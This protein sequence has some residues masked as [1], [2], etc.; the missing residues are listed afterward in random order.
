MGANRRARHTL[1]THRVDQRFSYVDTIYLEL[2]VGL[3]RLAI[4]VLRMDLV[5][6]L[7]PQ[8]SRYVQRRVTR[9]SADGRAFWYWTMLIHQPTLASIDVLLRTLIPF[10]ITQVHV[11]LDLLVPAG[12]DP[13]ALHR[14][15]ESRLIVSKTPRS[16]LE[17]AGESTTYFNKGTRRGSEVALYS[18]RCSKADRTCACLHIEWRLMGA[19]ALVR[20]GLRQLGDIV[21]LNHRKFWKERLVLWRP[22]SRDQVHAARRRLMKRNELDGSQDLQSTDVLVSHVFRFADGPDHDLIA[23]NLLCFLAEHRLL[24]G[25]RPTR[26]FK[27]EESDWM[28]PGELNAMWR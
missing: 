28:L 16:R 21:H 10:R 12:S 22:P 3:D 6:A 27:R 24:F 11:A 2:P 15:I 25:A 23:N 1:L 9:K 5:R 17:V 13:C 14:Y 26:M 7:R 20:A 4:R 18:D 19:Q 8:R